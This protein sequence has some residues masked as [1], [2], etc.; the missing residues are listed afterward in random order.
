VKK[1]VLLPDIH[2]PMN[3][4]MQPTFKFIRDYKPD[5]VVIPGDG[6]DFQSVSPWITDRGYKIDGLELAREYQ[7]FKQDILN[8]I[9][10]ATNAPIFY[11]KGNHEFWVDQA[12]LSNPN[13]RGYW[14]MENNIDIDKFKITMLEYGSVLKLG[15]LYIMHGN[16]ILD[17][18]AKKT[19]TVYE[20][21][22]I[23]CHTHDVQKYQKVVPL[24]LEPHIGESIGCLCHKNPH[25]RRNKPSDW[26]NAFCIVEWWGQGYFNHNVIHIIKGGFSYNGKVYK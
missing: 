3:I 1:G 16:Y 25:Y 17:Q 21:N 26:M 7:G 18:H 13:G 22:V 6:M 10:A 2:S 24:G 4:D 14:E 9:R 11:I 19:V 8:P 12:L 15:H 20:N 23:Y 5:I